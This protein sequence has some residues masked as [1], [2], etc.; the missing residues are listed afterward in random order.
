MSGSNDFGCQLIWNSNDLV[1]KW[2]GIQMILVVNWFQIQISVVASWFAI[3]MIWLS[4]DLIFT[5]FGCQLI[6]DSSDLVVNWF[7]IQITLVVNWFEVQM[8]WFSIDLRFKWCGCQLVCDSNDLVFSWFGIPVIWL[9][10]DLKLMCFGC[11]LVG[12]Q[13][14]WLSIGSS[15]K[16]FDCQS[17]IWDSS[18]QVIWD[19]S[20]DLRLK[21]CEI[22][23]VSNANFRFS[24]FE[25]QLV[26]DSI[27]WQVI[28]FQSHSRSEALKLQ[29]EA[30]LRDFLQKWSFEAQKRNFVCETSFKN[31]ACLRDFLQKWSFEAQKQSFSTKLPSKIKLWDSNTKLFYKTSFKNKAL[32]LKN[33]AFF[34]ETSF[35]KK[36]LKLKTKLF[37]ARLPSNINIKLWSSKT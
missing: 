10:L 17:L 22:Q 14:V 18:V 32:K 4:G 1:V 15:F 16:W 26:W 27:G 21:W 8:I 2:C 23:M 5:C 28:Q 7:E 24:C 25:I 33:A 3:Q 31:E 12:H 37:S 29:N 19:S 34:C 6:W 13:A 36:A 11:Q 9:S 30:S 20:S 35:K